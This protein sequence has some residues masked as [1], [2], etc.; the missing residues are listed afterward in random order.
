MVWD[1]TR[2]TDKY[3]WR[4]PSGC[5]AVIVLPEFRFVLK[6]DVLS[7]YPSSTE[8]YFPNGT[9]DLHY[10]TSIDASTKH[11][12]HFSVSTAEKKY[13][14]SADSSASRDEWV[15]T[16]RKVLFRCQN[17]GESVKVCSGIEFCTCWIR[18]SGSIGSPPF[19]GY[20]NADGVSPESVGRLLPLI[21]RFTYVNVDCDTLG[22]GHPY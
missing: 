9:V 11:P 14:F 19:W 15:K 17:E 22:G 3:Y 13:S 6:D 4:V 20:E 8:P 10:C 5:G 2:D 16:L 1:V 7:W 21:V 18:E 12:K